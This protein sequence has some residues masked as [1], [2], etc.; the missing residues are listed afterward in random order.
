MVLVLS[1]CFVAENYMDYKDDASSTGGASIDTI[2]DDYFTQNELSS[3]D[4]VKQLS[5][6]Q[7][8]NEACKSKIL[9]IDWLQ[10]Y[11]SFH[12]SKV[13]EI[14]DILTSFELCTLAAL[15]QITD[16]EAKLVADAIKGSSAK[17]VGSK[18]F[19]N[20]IKEL[21]K[22]VLNKADIVST[23]SQPNLTTSFSEEAQSQAGLVPTTVEENLH[24]DENFDD[25]DSLESVVQW[26]EQIVC[27]ERLEAEHAA[28]MNSIQ[29]INLLIMRANR[30]EERFSPVALETLKKSK[31]LHLQRAKRLHHVLYPPDG[32]PRSERR[33]IDSDDDIDN[34]EE[35]RIM[36]I[37]KAHNN[38]LPFSH[39]K[40]RRR[41]QRV[42][43]SIA[44]EE[45]EEV[46]DEKNLSSQVIVVKNDKKQESSHRRT[47]R[48]LLKHIPEDKLSNIRML[49]MFDVYCLSLF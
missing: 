16:E 13:G 12:E 19:L 43:F 45:E 38:Q 2:I 34:D 25:A 35:R 17:L 31:A 26:A 23:P 41:N 18:K 22:K 21:K 36:M 32:I 5:S 3:S 10:S 39:R 11:C 20:G 44:N 27:Y 9:L 14:Y 8:V 28:E 7:E 40:E 30:L 46:D 49:G 48:S 4:A 47:M 1:N 24:T 29:E 42:T 15:Y 37:Q 6:Q 33:M